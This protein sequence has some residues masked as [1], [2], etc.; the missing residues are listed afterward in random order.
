[1]KA[2]SRLTVP[3]VGFVLGAIQSL[4]G[5]LCCLLGVIGHQDQWTI[6]HEALGDSVRSCRSLSDCRA[7]YLG[8]VFAFAPAVRCDE[9]AI[10]NCSKH[11][12]TIERPSIAST[13]GF[14]RARQWRGDD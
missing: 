7:I 6:L 4:L 12:Q 11:Q 10:D 3:F 9:P 2:R 8:C 13:I 1:W 5:R 14:N